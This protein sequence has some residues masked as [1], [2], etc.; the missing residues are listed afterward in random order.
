MRKNTHGGS[1]RLYFKNKHIKVSNKI[2]KILNEEEK[3]G[4]KNFKVYKNLAKSFKNKRK[5]NKNLNDLKL[6][7]KYYWIWHL[8]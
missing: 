7:K 8:Q 2:N 3:Y 5:R 4:I 1:L 6:H